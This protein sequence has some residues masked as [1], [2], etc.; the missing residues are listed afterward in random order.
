MATGLA[1]HI[2]E[3]MG[4]GT[5]GFRNFDNEIIRENKKKRKLES[6]IPNIDLNA[7]DI[8]SPIPLNL[9][10]MKD[11]P[12]DWR[13][14]KYSGVDHFFYQTKHD[15]ERNTNEFEKINT[16]DFTPRTKEEREKFIQGYNPDNQGDGVWF[17]GRRSR[18]QRGRKLRKT[19]RKL[20]KRRRNKRKTKKRTTKSQ[21]RR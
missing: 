17:G 10:E 6:Q 3:D 4:S 15:K 21:K 12:P 14:N 5:Y 16:P 9:G 13:I 2:P 18:K 1:L 8:V 19:K 7:K 11:N 20:T